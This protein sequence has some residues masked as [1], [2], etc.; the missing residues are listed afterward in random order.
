MIFSLV[1]L[2]QSAPIED[3]VNLDEFANYPYKGSNLY[4][5]YISIS[6]T[7]SLHYVL[8]ES[9]TDA[10]NDPLVLVLNGGPGCSSLMEF[11]SENGPAVTIGDNSKI[12]KINPFSWNKNA[13]VLYLE[14]PAG[15]GFST[16]T[17]PNYSTNDDITA[18]DNLL[19]LQL[20]FKTKFPEYIKNRFNNSLNKINL[21][22]AFETNIELL[23]PT[24]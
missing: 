17:D 11:I 8:V 20:F 10:V 14:A 3:K 15:V 24:L 23:E 6:A 18:S 1:L 19:V 4:S 9:Q 7:K 5:G 13:N 2:I 22:N 12:L 21:K 16:Q